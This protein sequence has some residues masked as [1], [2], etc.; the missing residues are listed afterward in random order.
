VLR[1]SI[2]IPARNESQ[3]ILPTLTEYYEYYS[4]VSSNFEIVVVC[5]ECTDRTYDLVL[6]FAKNGHPKVAALEYGSIGGKGGAIKE[7][8]RYAAGEIKMFID[9]DCSTAAVQSHKLIQQIQKNGYSVAIASRKMIGAKIGRKQPLIRRLASWGYHGLVSLLFGLPFMDIQVGAK[10]FTAD[11]AKVVVNQVSTNGW[12][13]DTDCVWTLYRK[14]VSIV[15]VPVVWT[16]S[17]NSTLK[18][19]Q[20]VITMAF[21]LLKLR[22]GLTEKGE[23]ATYE[24]AYGIKSIR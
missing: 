20:A 18:I 11:A 4:R 24:R 3:R 16:D 15:E 22:L 19:H 5:N 7:G 8:L 9:A 12:A 17:R 6:S 1:L 14:G 13:F 23:R 21:E 2:I 10:A